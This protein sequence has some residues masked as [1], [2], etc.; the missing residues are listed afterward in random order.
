ME[1]KSGDDGKEEEI[2]KRI[3][4]NIGYPRKIGSMSESSQFVLKRQLLLLKE[5]SNEGS[6]FGGK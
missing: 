3:R 4:L 6:L 5:P 2:E 1:N